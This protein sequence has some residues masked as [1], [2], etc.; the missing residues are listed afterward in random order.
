MTARSF[1]A[2]AAALLLGVAIGSAWQRSRRESRSEDVVSAEF[3]LVQ[4]HP[5][6]PSCAQ[7]TADPSGTLPVSDGT[8]HW[9]YMASTH[10]LQR[11]VVTRNL[12]TGYD[13]R[14]VDCSGTA[15]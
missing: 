3:A 6:Q 1:L 10:K 7:L 9:R 14:D 11:L 4:S 15:R 12:E 8:V 5:Q 2:P 13:E